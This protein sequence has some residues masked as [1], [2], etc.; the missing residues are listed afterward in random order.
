MG[1]DVCLL[2]KL[3][4]AETSSLQHQKDFV[5]PDAYLHFI[6]LEVGFHTLF[7]C[8]MKASIVRQVAYRRLDLSSKESLPL[9]FMSTICSALFIAIPA[10][11]ELSSKMNMRICRAII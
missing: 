8:Y 4:R 11:N 10:Q 6:S 7:C 1:V 2:Y 3:S 9:K 5:F